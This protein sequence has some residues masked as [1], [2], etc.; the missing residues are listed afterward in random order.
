MRRI[1][2]FCGAAKVLENPFNDGWCL[3]A[4]D[5]TQ[6]PAALP[7]G[8]DVDGEHPPERLAGANTPW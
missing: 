3:N 2:G 7:A 4:G 8:L 5:D 6:V 1:D